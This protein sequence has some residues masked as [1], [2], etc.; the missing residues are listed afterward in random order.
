MLSIVG[1]NTVI[2]AVTGMLA[3]GCAGEKEGDEQSQAVPLPVAWPR[4]DIST[5]D[6]MRTVQ[7][8]PVEVLINPE[9]DYEIV[10]GD[11]KGLTVTYPK[12][13][14]KIYYTFIAPSDSAERRK[15]IENRMQRISL[16]LNGIT[17][18]T[19]HDE[20]EQGVLVVASSGSQTPVQLLADLPDFVVTGTAFFMDPA[21]SVA[22]DSISPIIKVLEYDM[23]RSLPMLKFGNI[24]N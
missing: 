3:T 23:S 11:P 18:E 16:N 19:L 10:E 17:A 2:V 7:E 14:T 9:A 15:I 5:S 20:T 1:R 21:T 22:Y 8:V 13:N 24:G 6:S 4:L 12:V